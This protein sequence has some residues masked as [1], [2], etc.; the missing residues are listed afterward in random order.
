ML[1]NKPFA[2][3][4]Q[5]NPR[6]IHNIGKLYQL[7]KIE[8][9]EHLHPNYM[10][11]AQYFMQAQLPE[12]FEELAMLCLEGKI[13]LCD[14][15]V[16]MCNGEGEIDHVGFVTFAAKSTNKKLWHNI[17]M[18]YHNGTINKDGDHIFVSPAG[19]EPNFLEAAQWF[20]KAQTPYSH[21]HLGVLFFD[22]KI[23]L[24]NGTLKR[25]NS[26]PNYE[27]AIK[28]FTLADSENSK[29]NLAFLLS[30]PDT[31]F[32]NYDRAK[33]LYLAA[34]TSDSLHNVAAMYAKGKIGLLTNGNHYYTQAL[35]Y[36]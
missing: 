33:N 30:R 14:G 22:G 32:T 34:N 5:K 23:T 20:L 24:E 2:R 25:G 1:K 17:G 27:Q 7:G 35:F 28:Y 15:T 8:P 6:A 29:H 31:P 21:N 4:W 18:R 12:S 3:T 9:L 36:A 19:A 10:R 16:Q 26:L 11:A 13:K